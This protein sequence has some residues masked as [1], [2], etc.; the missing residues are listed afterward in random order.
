VRAKPSAPV[1]APCTWEEVERG[2]VHPRSFT[3]RT[4]PQRV[5][6]VGDLWFRLLRS[7]RSLKKAIDSLAQKGQQD[8]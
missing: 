1:S 4:M 5:A 7:K 3:L 6:E 8:V 2:V